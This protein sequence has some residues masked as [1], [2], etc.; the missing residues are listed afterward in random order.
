MVRHKIG[1]DS[2]IG[3]SCLLKLKTESKLKWLCADLAAAL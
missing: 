1:V 3:G 2:E